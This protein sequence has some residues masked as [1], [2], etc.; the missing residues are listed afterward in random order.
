M[1]RNVWGRVSAIRACYEMQLHVKR[2]LAGKVTIQWVTDLTG[3]VKGVKAVQNS[4]GSVELSRCIVKVI[5]KIHFQPPEGGMC[6]VR[7]PFVFSPGG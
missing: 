3:K 4:T 1:Q 2:K 5:G 6:I 7:W